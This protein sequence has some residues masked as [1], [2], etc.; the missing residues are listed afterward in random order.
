[1]DDRQKT[2]A[3]LTIIFGFIAFVVILVVILLAGRKVISPV[4]DD[5]AIKIIFLSPTPVST[6]PATP[7]ASPAETP[8]P[9]NKT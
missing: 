7:T 1:M 9:K 6:E 8:A 5:N 2:F 3:A 4:P